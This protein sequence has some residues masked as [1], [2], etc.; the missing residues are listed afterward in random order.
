MNIPELGKLD[1]TE[2]QLSGLAAAN[3]AANTERVAAE[4]EPLTDA[5]YAANRLRQLFDGYSEQHVDAPMRDAIL[6]KL[7][8]RDPATRKAAMEAAAASLE[9]I[10]DVAVVED[11]QK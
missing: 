4:K 2:D 1:F 10:P 6:K 8:S 3:A 7:N 11:V 5:E 9:A